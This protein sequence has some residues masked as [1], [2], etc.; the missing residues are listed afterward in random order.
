M[1]Q[2]KLWQGRFSKDTA[3]IFDEFNA[4][5]MVDINLFEYDVMGS[6]AHVKMLSKCDIIPEDEGKL[7]VNTLYEILNDFKEGKIEFDMSDEDVHMLIEKELIKRIGQVGKKV[8]TARSRND[9]VVLDERLFCRE[10][11]LYLQ[12]L[13]KN[14]IDTII[15]LA[16][17]NI[18]TIMPGF[19][20]LQKAQPVLFSHYILAYAQML[21]RDLLRFRQNFISINLNPLGSAALAGTTFDIDRFL[22]QI[23]LNLTELQKIV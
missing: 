12:E 11:N 16:E 15:K 13:I 3:R 9:Q 8:H 1:I 22:W 17:E 6:V 23:S 20:H 18:D 7:I 4:S 2:I 21:K 19:T 14:L 5:I 10:K